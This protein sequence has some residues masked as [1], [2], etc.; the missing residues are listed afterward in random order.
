MTDRSRRAFIKGGS[1]AIAGLG[2][3]GTAG[4]AAAADT[5]SINI[6]ASDATQFGE[7]VYI[8]GD[9]DALGNWETAYK[10]TPESGYW[11]YKTDLPVGTEYKI[12]KDQW[13]D[14][15]TISTEGVEWEVGD[16]HVVQDGQ[17]VASLYPEF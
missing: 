1:A 8:T 17:T 4:T 5:Q 7:A 16:N 2:V 9:V 13:V 14:G 3:L 6:Y 10:M 15:E 11:A 12:V